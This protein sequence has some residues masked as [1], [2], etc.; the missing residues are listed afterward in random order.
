M[1]IIKSGVNQWIFQRIANATFII[2]GIGLLC[3]LMSA[4]SLSFGG[5]QTLLATTWVKIWLCVTLILACLNGV[6]AAWQIDGDYA[7][8]FGLPYL[9]ITVS[10]VLVGLVYLIYGFQFLFQ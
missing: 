7:K 1:G 10:A 8:K 3:V 2:F 5:L 6:L 4:D 9:V